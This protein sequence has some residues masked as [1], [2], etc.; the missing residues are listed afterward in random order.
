MAAVTADSGTTGGLQ[1]I[2]DKAQV[3]GI[4]GKRLLDIEVLDFNVLS[5]TT[6]SVL[7]SLLTLVFL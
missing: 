6:K 2:C 4:T 7:S 5:L 3:I 1:V